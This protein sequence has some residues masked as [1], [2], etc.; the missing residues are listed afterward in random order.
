MAP[1]TG[2]L[3]AAK[4]LTEGEKNRSI[5]RQTSLP[6]SFAF[7]KIHL[8]RQREASEFAENYL[9]SPNRGAVGAAD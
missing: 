5:P 9:G 3:A 7:G 1:L 6:P 8:P 4:P 2:E